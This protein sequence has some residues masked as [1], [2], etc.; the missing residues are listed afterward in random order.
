MKTKRVERLLKL[1]QALHSGDQ[2]A[3]DDL[4]ALC[5]VDRR[6]V[7]RDLRLL[8]RSGLPFTYD[9]GTKRYR[10]D[11]HALLPPVPLTHEEA[12]ALLI[13]TRAMMSGPLLPWPEAAAAAGLKIESMLPPTIL[14]HCGPLME[15]VEIRLSPASDP[16]SIAAT[17]PI[18]QTALAQRRKLAVDYDSYN[19]RKRIDVVLRPHRLLHLRRG[20]YVIAWQEDAGAVRTFKVERI[21]HITLL[22]ETFTID[23]KFTLDDYFGNAWLMIRGDKRYHVKLRF[24]PKVAGNVEEIVWH[25]TQRTEYEDDGSLLFEVDVDGIQEIVWWVLGYGDQAV[26]LEPAELRRVVGAHARRLCAVYADT[27]PTMPPRDARD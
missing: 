14:D 25:K 4:A 22:D 17:L 3:V 24:A 18:V 7:F 13:V 20:W 26:V 15:N 5:G 2:S 21:I 11:R 23:P 12:L 19:E 8:K 6:T 27:D 16:R 9:R 10:A 1:I